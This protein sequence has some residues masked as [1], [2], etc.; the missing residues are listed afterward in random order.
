MKVRRQAYWAAG[1]AAL[2][3]AR[4]LYRKF[5]QE[6]IAGQAVLITGGSRGLGLAMARAFAAQGCRIAICARDG[7]ELE[8]ARQDL[9]QRG[10][11][12]YTAVCDIADRAQVERLIEDVMEHYGSIDI[13]VNNAGIIQVGPVESMTVEDFRQAMDVMFWGTVY[14]T[15]ALLPHLLRRRSGRIV[16]I[17]SIGGKVAVPHLLPYTCAKFAAVGFS[18]GLRAEVASQG[19]KVVTI[20]PGLMRTGS[21]LN[22]WFKGDHDRESLW[23]GLG[24]SLPVVTISAK[25]AADQIVAATRRGEAECVL[26]TPATLLARFHGMFPGLTAHMNSLVNRL[27][28]PAPSADSSSKRGWE[29]PS[30]HTRTVRTLTGLGHAGARDFLQPQASGPR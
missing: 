26:S 14:P 6:D 16:N 22:A 30:L 20:A 18:E 25:R 5:S 29:T 24:A 9:A 23:F 11:P 7:D 19:V 10:A 1:A 28:L 8:R 3:A 12:V 2:V 15:M 27:A 21:F 4:T 13:L 17:T